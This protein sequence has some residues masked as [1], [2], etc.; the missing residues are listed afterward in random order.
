MALETALACQ[1][2]DRVTKAL[3]TNSGGGW[4]GHVQLAL[5][6]IQNF[7][8]LPRVRAAV[9]NLVWFTHIRV[10]RCIR[11]KRAYQ[12]GN[13]PTLFLGI[14]ALPK[15]A[16]VEKQV[17]LHTGRFLVPVDDEIEVKTINPEVTAGKMRVSAL[18][19]MLTRPTIPRGSI[20]SNCI[21]TLDEI[22]IREQCLPCDIALHSRRDR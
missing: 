19:P 2:V 14:P 13:T 7:A 5:Y 18:G 9:K 10:L 22:R 21:G 11:L 17:M 20:E 6:W 12:H 16:L 1:H 3:K 15:G 8:D 4:E